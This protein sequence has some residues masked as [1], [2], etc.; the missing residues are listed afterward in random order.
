VKLPP[1]PPGGPAAKGLVA[2]AK[3]LVA[4]AK[5]LVA[6]VV[7]APEYPST[8]AAAKGLTYA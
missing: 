7:A 6:A 1:P 5:G 8:G 4:A 3:G 2:A